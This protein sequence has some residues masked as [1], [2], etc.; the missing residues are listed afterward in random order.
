MRQLIGLSVAFSLAACGGSSSNNPDAGPPDGGAPTNSGFTVPTKAAH[1]YESPSAK[2]FNDL[3]LADWSCLGTPSADKALTADLTL[4]GEVHDFQTTTTKVPNAT[5]DVFADID[6]AH[7]FKTV[8]T[9]NA[10]AFTVTIPAGK[11]RVGFK[12][13]AANYQDTLLLNQY[14]DGTKATET[15]EIG[16]IASGLASALPAL[17]NF[18]RTPGTG[19]L[20]GAM[21]DCAHHEVANVIATVSSTPMTVT[22]LSGSIQVGTPPVATPVVATTFYFNA[23][24]GLPARHTGTSARVMTDPDG[25]F[26]VFDL[27]PTEAAYIQVWGFK[28]D[29][30]VAKGEAGLTLLAELK[31]PVISENVITASIEVLRTH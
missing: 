7:P 23:S 11:T 13:K 9:D 12:M 28:T 18:D 25:L 6:Y 19:V 31:S 1:A 21:R 27:P 8:T 2:V 17:V 10:G 24:A 22:H 5:V 4:T 16:D 29:A 26:A 15:I 14:W 3:G 20:A 30:D